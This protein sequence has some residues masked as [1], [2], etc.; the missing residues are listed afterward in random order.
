MKIKQKLQY[1]GGTSFFDQIS[2]DALKSIIE[3]WK[4]D[5][6][7]WGQLVIDADWDYDDTIEYSLMGEREETEQ[8]AQTRTLQA[9]AYAD[10]ERSRELALLCK[11]KAKYEQ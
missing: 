11:L 10:S 2:L 9:K 6:P 1:I 5:Y 8:E 3:Q 4:R 7:G